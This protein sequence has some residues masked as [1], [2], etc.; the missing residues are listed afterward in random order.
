MGI[1][2]FVLFVSFLFSVILPISVLRS[3]ERKGE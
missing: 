1:Q 2:F 3:C